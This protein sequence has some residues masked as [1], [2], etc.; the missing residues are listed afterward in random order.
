MRY[1]RC[2]I[3]MNDDVPISISEQ[4][5]QMTEDSQ[6]SYIPLVSK[7]R[8]TI[9]RQIEVV[10][11]IDRS[12]EDRYQSKAIVL[13]G[14][15]IDIFTLMLLSEYQPKTY[16]IDSKRDFDNIEECSKNFDD[17]QQMSYLLRQ[18]EQSYFSAFDRIKKFSP[19]NVFRDEYIERIFQLAYW[20]NKPNAESATKV[21]IKSQLKVGILN[22]LDR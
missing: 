2:F 12:L 9:E 19:E 3:V 5:H 4:L 17:Y 21:W 6:N 10:R 18:A 13:S 11:K 1:P 22:R 7:S 8:K 16:W 14:K 20:N 15:E